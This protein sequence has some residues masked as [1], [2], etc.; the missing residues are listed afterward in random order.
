[1]ALA[2]ALGAMSVLSAGISIR[3]RRQEIKFA[4]KQKKLNDLITQ[5]RFANAAQRAAMSKAGF[6][7]EEREAQLE[8][9]IVAMQ[10]TGAAKVASAVT[11]ITGNSIDNALVSIQRQKG[12]AFANIDEEIDS[13]L[14]EID[15]QMAQNLE[16]LQDALASGKV[17]DMSSD[18]GDA[19]NLV[20]AGMQGYL[21]GGGFSTPR[22]GSLSPGVNTVT[23]GTL[24]GNQFGG[25]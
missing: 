15:L 21:A 12:N 6:I 9:E 3:Q 18:F 23:S 4:K 10:E 19:L 1:M 17:V 2:L 24:A 8:A 14:T 7:G 20:T 25:R 11:G 16:N 5:T 13:Y 22:V